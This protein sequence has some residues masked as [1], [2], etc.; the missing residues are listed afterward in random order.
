[1]ASGNE[2]PGTDQYIEL[3]MGRSTMDYAMIHL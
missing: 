3:D 2:Q 1:M